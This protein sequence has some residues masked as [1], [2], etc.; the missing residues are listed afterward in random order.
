MRV[1]IYDHAGTVISWTTE[2]LSADPDVTLIGP[3]QDRVILYNLLRGRRI[4]IAVVGMKQCCEFLD[5]YNSIYWRQP[6]ALKKMCLGSFVND[7]T[8]D[9]A[10][11]LGFDDIIDSTD[12]RDA[13]RRQIRDL[14][15]GRRHITDLSGPDAD[16]DDPHTLSVHLNDVIDREIVRLISRGY[17]DREIAEWV[18]LSPQTVRNRVSRLLERSGARNRTQLAVLFVRGQVTW[19]TESG[20]LER[21]A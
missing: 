3:A 2:V 18:Y 14:H 5:V 10:L 19:T 13:I 16:T 21:S 15:E 12:E 6:P 11:Q 17:A 4:D 1:L 20:D 7:A 8:M 9:W